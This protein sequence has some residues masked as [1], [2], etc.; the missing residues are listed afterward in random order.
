MTGDLAAFLNFVQG[1]AQTIAA[2]I[3]V[4]LVWDIKRN[5]LTH[6]YERL[7]EIEQLAWRQAG[8]ADAEIE[9]RRRK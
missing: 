6:I 4:Y 9:E 7:G 1:A 8:R 2:P 5:H 3:L